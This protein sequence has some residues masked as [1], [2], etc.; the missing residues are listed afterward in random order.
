MEIKKNP[1]ANLEK[2]KSIFLQIG[3][4][5]TL[6]VVL[7]AFEWSVSE[8]S[9]KDIADNRAKELDEQEEVDVTQQEIQQPPPPPQQQV[10]EEI[11]VVEDDVEI[12]DD[13]EIQDMDFQEDT[14]I[15]ITDLVEEETSDEVFQFAIIEDKPE[16][17][18]GDAALLSYL[19]KETKYPEMA[20][21]AGIKGTVYVGFVI[22]KDGSVGGVSIM[23]SVDKLLDDEALRVVKSMPKW[24]PGKQRG[25]AVRVSY[26]V[27]IKFTLAN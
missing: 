5:I 4:V 17:P 12:E 25:K 24:K 16:F 18:G 2:R 11:E 26:H 7:L 22:E 21:E 9:I 1:K 20:V 6:S 14:Q 3:L 19:G 8:T 13:I 23:R 10:I 15:E 27:P